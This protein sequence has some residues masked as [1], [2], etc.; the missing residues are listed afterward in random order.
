[1]GYA[2]K[3]F[4][5]HCSLRSHLPTSLDPSGQSS[6][7]QRRGEGDCFQR[8]LP[9]A[10]KPQV[11]SL[12]LE[13]ELPK[14]PLA[15]HRGFL[16]PGDFTQN[17]PPAHPAASRSAC[18]VGEGSLTDCL[19]RYRQGLGKPTRG[20]AVAQGWRKW[21]APERGAGGGGLSDTGNCGSGTRPAHGNLA[22]REPAS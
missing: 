13:M 14:L 22:R 8:S 4:G 5:D 7:S 9:P 15:A 19:Q 12:L 11:L 10:W 2:L 3:T 6:L 1:M 20:T 18:P 16:Q 21:R 17:H